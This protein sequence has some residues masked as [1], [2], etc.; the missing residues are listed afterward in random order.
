MPGAW[1]A[2]VQHD[3]YYIRQVGEHFEFMHAPM[4]LWVGKWVPVMARTLEDAQGV[5]QK[6]IIGD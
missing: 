6:I 5:V 4:M 1:V 3:Q 2:D